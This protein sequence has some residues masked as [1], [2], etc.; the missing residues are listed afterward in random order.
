MNNIRETYFHDLIQQDIQVQKNLLSILELPEDISQL[1]LIHEDTYINGITADFT[2]LY[3]NSVYAIIE[4][5]AADIWVTDYVRWI[6]QVLQYE[7]FYENNISP[8]NYHYNEKFNSILLIPSSVF[9]N[10]NLNLGKFKYPETT[11]II[12]I[13]EINHVARLIS[14][15]ELQELSKVDEDNLTSISQYYVRDNRLFE[16]YMLLRY[17]CL[18]KIRGVNE[19]NRRAIETELKKT[20][21]INNNNWRNAWISLSSLGF[22]NSKNMPTYAWSQFGMMEIEDFLCMLY[23]SYL[24]PY[25]N[26]LVEYFQENNQNKTKWLR[27]I[28]DDLLQ[29][30]SYK[31]VLFLTQSETRYLSSWLNILRDDFGCI[32]FQARNSNR[33]IKYNPSI[34]NDHA[35]KINIKQNTKSRTYIDNLRYIL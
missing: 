9:Q 26:I 33:V 10:K 27:G 12:E 34:L 21:T 19:V 22:I 8:K 25:I 13:N 17:L 35:L 15:R 1:Q 6:W 20:K 14:S 23:K 31:E 16:L 32:D 3:N 24:Y 7:F 29:K 2:L 28:K 4:C 18:L 11:K 30:F 5:K